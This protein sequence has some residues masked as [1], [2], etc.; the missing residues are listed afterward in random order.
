MVVVGGG[1]GL[2]AKLDDV[3]G[4]GHSEFVAHCLC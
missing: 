1:G 3:D 4:F 2:I